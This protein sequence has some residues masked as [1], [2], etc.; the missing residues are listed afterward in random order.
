MLYV[1][2]ISEW[3]DCRYHNG[4]SEQFGGRL[5]RGLPRKATGIDL[6]FAV[7]KAGEASQTNGRAHSCREDLTFQ[8]NPRVAA[9]LIY[10]EQTRSRILLICVCSLLSDLKPLIGGRA[11]PRK[12]TS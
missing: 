8:A 10:L 5:G 9:T 12:S 1:K 6:I 3:N 7:L 2:A 11:M 4:A